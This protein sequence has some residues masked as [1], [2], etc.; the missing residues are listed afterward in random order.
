MVDSRTT[1]RLRSPRMGTVSPTPRCA[2]ASRAGTMT[3]QSPGIDGSARSELARTRESQSE[4]SWSPDGTRIAFV[5]D[6][7]LHTMAADGSDVRSIV[8][9]I[10]VKWEP[11][12]LVPGRVTASVPCLAVALG[13]PVRSPVRR[14]RRRIKTDE[15]RRGGEPGLALA[16]S[17]VAG[18]PVCCV[19]HQGPAPEAAVPRSFGRRRGER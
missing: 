13:F 1:R 15:G 18:R 10:P 11:P 6:R 17:V 8:P 4:R 7:Y 3:S 19:R 5:R 14:E 9:D 12:Q 2:T 16:A